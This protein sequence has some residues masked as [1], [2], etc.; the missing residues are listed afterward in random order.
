MLPVRVRLATILIPAGH[1]ATENG[2]VL[3]E[4]NRTLAEILTGAGY[5]TGCFVSAKPSLGKQTGFDQGFADF[6]DGRVARRTAP[7]VVKDVQDILDDDDGRPFFMWA[8]FYDIH[9]PCR[10]PRDFPTR[11][12]PGKPAV[13]SSIDELKEDGALAAEDLELIRGRVTTRGS[14]A[15]TTACSRSGN[16]WSARAC[17]RRRWWW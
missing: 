9:R 2:Y 10:T 5:R 7:Q 4:E 11:F 6:N 12:T 8:H 15:W 14:P 16:A 17:W 3:T 13:L 1:D